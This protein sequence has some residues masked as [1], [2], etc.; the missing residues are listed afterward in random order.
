MW[1]PSGGWFS[2]VSKNSKSFRGVWRNFGH[3]YVHCYMWTTNLKFS[4]EPPYKMWQWH[5]KAGSMIQIIRVSILRDCDTNC[6]CLIYV[7]WRMDAG[8]SYPVQLAIIWHRLV[9]VWPIRFNSLSIS[10]NTMLIS[11]WTFWR[12][13]WANLSCSEST[14]GSYACEFYSAAIINSIDVPLVEVN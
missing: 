4:A 9:V 5:F 6:W 13:S 10:Q 2:S 3:A 1:T 8:F 7:T 14:L 12:N 11:I